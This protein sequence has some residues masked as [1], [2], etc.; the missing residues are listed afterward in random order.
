MAEA[1]SAAVSPPPP[2]LDVGSRFPL[3]LIKSEIIPP[4][5]SRS[6]CGS[7]AAADFLLDFAGHSWIAYGAASLV[8]ISHLPDPLSEAETRIGPIYHQVIELSREADA[9]VSAVC[10][11]PATPSIGEL[12][13]ALGDR[14][15]LLSYGGDENP[16]SSFCWRQT[17]MLVLSMKVEAIQWTV[18]GDGIISGGI[19]VVMWRKK[20]K[21]WEIAW[22]FKPKIPQVLVSTTWSACGLSATAPWS[23]VQVGGSSAFPNDAGDCVL[24]F[25]FDGHSKYPQHELRHPM[26]IGMIQWRPSTGKPPSK[27]AKHAQ[28]PI[29]LTC[30]LDGSVR[31]WGEIDD[32]RIRRNVKDNSD[33]K[34]KLSFCVLS[35]IEVNQTLN[36][37]LGSDVFVR[38]AM[39]V[40][41]VTVNDKEVC[42]YSCSD[43]LQHD[44][45]AR[46]EWLIGFGRERVIT[47]WA[48]HCLDDFA[49]VRFPRVTLWKKH[50]LVSSV[51]EPSQLLMHKVCIMRTQV[52]GSPALCS[53]VQ[54]SPCNS[55]S[56]WQLYS[57]TSASMK[58]ESASDVHA[59]SSLAACA[60]GV[61]EVEGHIDKIL[62]IAVHPFSFEVKLAAS[63]DRNG[64]LLFW[65]FSTFFNSHI[66]Q[67]I[68]TPSWKLCGKPAIIDHSPKYTCLS[69]APTVLGDSNVLLMGHSNGIDCFLVKVLKNNEQKIT[70]HNLFSLPLVI[71]GQEQVLTRMSS[72][73]LPCNCDGNS[74]SSKFLLIAL[75]M[76]TFRAL[77]WEITIHCDY[78]QGSCL[79]DHWKTFEGDFSGKQYLVAVDPAS[80]VI[81]V[82]NNDD[83][84]TSCAVVCPSDL[85]SS[86]QKLSSPDEIGST[87]YAY[88]MIT[89]CFNGSLKLWRS[90]PLD[91]L[92]SDKKWALVGV[93]TS[94]Q[95]P[96]LNVSMS[97]CGQKIASASK[98]SLSKNHSTTLCIWECLHVKGVGSFMLEDKLCFDGVIVAFN[99][100]KM[101]I[102][103]LLLAVC[104]Q[105]DLR[106]YAS[107]RRGGQGELKSEKPMEE[108]AWICIAAKSNLPPISD[109]LWGPKGT[110]VVVHDKYFSI[111]SHFLSLSDYTGSHDIVHYSTFTDSEKALSKIGGKYE[112]QPP[113]K[114][115]NNVESFQWYSYATEKCFWSMS[116]IAEKIGGSL[117]LFHPEAL[118]NNLCSGN[119]KRAFI[120]LRHLAKHLASGTLSEQ[121]HG[122][123]MPSSLVSPVPL[124]DYLDGIL[125]LHSSGNVF[126]WSTSQLHTGLFNSVPEG[127]YGAHNSTMTS[128]LSKSEFDG[129][130]ESLESLHSYNCINTD[131][132]IQA[133]ALVDL[134]RE[135]GNA[136]ST[137]AYGSLD[138]PGRR[139]WVAVR[140]QQLYFAQRYSRLPL[141]EEFVV[142][143][144]LIGWAFHSD[145]HDNLFNSLLPTEPSWEEMRSMGVGFWYTNVSQLR[146]KMEKL[147]RQQ[148]M[149]KKDPKACL[150]LYIVLNRLQVLAGLFKISKD[151]K[152]KPLAG[153]LFRN[154]QE[155]KHKA[156]AIKNAYVLL[157]KHQ[158]ELAVAFFLLGGDAS[159]AVTVCAKNLGDEQLALVICRLIE[160]CGG[161][162]ECNLIVKFLLP[163]A[164]SKGD[165]WMASFLEWLLG[166]YPQSFFRMLGAEVGSEVNISV[167]SSSH[168]CFLDPSIGQYC[169]M[170]ANKT[171][172]KNAVGELNAANL[173]RWASLMNITSFR[174]CGLPLEALESLL[175]SV[176]IFGGP[177]HGSLTHNPTGDLPA[178]LTQPSVYE[179]SSNWMLEET[180]FHIISYCK[181]YLA[182]QYM[183]T[184]MKEHP[185]SLENDRPSSFK[186]AIN[187]EVDRQDFEKLLKEFEDKLTE[188]ITY[189]QQKFLLVP[190]HLIKMIV[191]SLCHNG[192]D[193]IGHYIL[194]DY[195]PKF[196]SQE[197]S[198]RPDDL[199][200]SPSNL[201]KATEE[202]LSLY[203]K[204]I[205][206]SCKNCLR[207][208]YFS[209]DSL[210]SE[211]RLCWLTVWGLSDQ[212]M[213]ETFMCLRAML[214]LFLRSQA[215]DFQKLL[216]FVVSLFE[217]HI[218]F[219][220]AWL[221]KNFKAIIV[222]IGPI[223]SNLLDES[224]S[225]GLKME[226]L[227]KLISE[228]MELLAHGLVY[229]ESG[230]KQEPSGAVSDNKAWHIISSSFWVCMSKFLE[231][232][233]S[234]LPEV[235]EDFFSSGPPPVLE[236]DGNN[237]QQQARLTS[238]TLVQ[239]LKLTCSDISFYCSKQFAT[240]LLQEA[241]TLNKNNLSSFENGL[242]QSGGE[243]INP[244]I[245]YP[246]PLDHGNELPDLDKLRNIFA[247][248]EILRGTFE[249][250]YHNW[251]PYIK[252]KS[253]SGW[254]YAYASITAEFGLEENWDKED[255]FG[256]PRAIGSP[257][258]CTTPDHPF[259]TSD[260]NN[261]CDSKRV[262]P[263]QNP[264]EICRRN[265]ELLEALCINSIDQSQATL[266]S[267][268]KGIV[269]F[270]WEDGIPDRYKAEC[271][272][273]EADW[274]HNG[275]AG[276]ESTPVPTNGSS[277]VGFGSKKATHLGLGGA[278]IGAGSLVQPG[279]ELTG[280]GAFGIPGYAGMG[281][282]SLDW[283]LQESFDE[284]LDPPATIDSVRTSA[285]ASHPCRPFFLVGSSNTRIY[286]WE[287]GKGT[288]TA[289]YGVLPAANVPTPYALATVSAARFDHCG[290]R[291]VTAALDG[292]VCTWQLEVGGRSNIHPT[293][294]SVCFNNHTADVTYVTASGS[295][296]A[297]AGYSSNGVNVVVWDTLAPPATSQAS[298]MCHEGGARS[299]AVFDNDIGSGS[300]SPLILTGGKGGD[301]GLHDFRYIATGRTKKH[302]HL[303]PGEHNMNA[304]SSVDMRS[305][306][307]DQNRNGMLWYIPKA[308]S[309]SITKISTI[310]NTSF[311]LTGSKDGDVKLWDAKR[312]KLVFHWPKLHER[313]TFL[314]PSSRG[315]GGVVRAAV[316]D[317]QVVSNGFLTCGGDGI[318]KYIG[319]QGNP[320]ETTN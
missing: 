61:L 228:V 287:F 237:L 6:R 96:I 195:A 192:L 168:T 272:W 136:N 93:L 264:K 16:T 121:G 285:F 152:D 141:V 106:I 276:Y 281:A 65:S 286:L 306:T 282:S 35:V 69:W 27:H 144:G 153:F 133:I 128:S 236:L 283:D 120:A 214:Q 20:E 150:L 110:A 117:P 49:P 48:I 207:S 161:P 76:D 90:M 62:Q 249:K 317:I 33:H 232:Q 54:L 175:S 244:M 129:F 17:T 56:W 156:A 216:L 177:T 29:L 126:H 190:L 270:N 277:A 174:R 199:F 225:N 151:E 137:S 139:F 5:P 182:L 143:P 146:V 279:G 58:L 13:V 184:L 266:A 206:A 8:V 288:A 241:N 239:F 253:S 91:S 73:P 60:K 311:F 119:W 233:L 145:C 74:V 63:L 299:L 92:S 23:E 181:L 98:N 37:I 75:W 312:A 297:A 132:K 194:Q 164:L 212:G 257:L 176:S 113:A 95:G 305:K 315:F 163:S 172:L 230:Q 265:G 256:S 180:S 52:S 31:L 252:Q 64:M 9:H 147:A 178:E 114:M 269:Y 88:H 81:P 135:V 97:P 157:G 21:S 208:T 7:A 318:V 3:H 310:P 294:S 44:T 238:S 254:S 183:S 154:F 111:F 200:C 42:Y 268:K 166:N 87:C 105:N 298:I 198:N 169:L 203:V 14:I 218:L 47:M 15:F 313:H 167:L 100:L 191:L 50:D 142:S 170:L 280:G 1:T 221:Q 66:G 293:E 155:D 196:L 193:F 308:H 40:E 131:E 189:F 173:C 57:Q 224:G 304:S 45:A 22:S 296:V 55:F 138:E 89:G 316:T 36:G 188:A 39:D 229:V 127:G 215:V 160:G 314:Q 99:W 82:T 101:G 251:L 248:S 220:T 234:T 309:G 86:S 11:S 295:I 102:G 103:Q 211:G 148:Y 32:G 83:K 319:F 94:Q 4:A 80:S 28:R 307:G 122:A 43:N 26:P 158:L 116:E 107:R 171:K 34:A 123:K 246:K 255:G 260:D 140:F 112:S 109:F 240:Y 245:E 302:K 70:Y 108:N 130:I 149:K 217:F 185:S 84:V 267:N 85:V 30:C 59:N 18:S 12:A 77:S 72:I 197:K 41:G 247:G 125:P 291:F 263:F 79:N 290:H 273:G 25:Q 201:F 222:S 78:S 205:V 124:S 242:Y 262:M 213:T 19:D 303:D 24:V 210:S 46:C 134:L 104:S 159:S 2:P 274:P 292:T 118:F 71:E 204:Y 227:N 68:S 162:L 275:W 67:P 261:T 165:F 250:E 284:F 53:L 258:A 51:V 231:H 320:L 187:L 179:N 226:N 223:L 10:W 186:E 209:V 202:M 259:K 115:K 235:P 243:N 289:T 38:W 271:I 219:A 278:T 300:V 301:V